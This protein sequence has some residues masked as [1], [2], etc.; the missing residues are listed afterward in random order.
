MKKV[1]SLGVLGILL[2]SGMAIAQSSPDGSGGAMQGARNAAAAAAKESS[3]LLGGQTPAAKVEDKAS[4][5]VVEPVKEA[6]PGESA[7]VVLSPGTVTAG[8][9]NSGIISEASKMGEEVLILQNRQKFFDQ[10]KQTV[11]MIGVENTLK[12]YPE[13]A[14]YLD[15]SPMALQSQLSRVQTLNQLREEVAKANGPTQYERDMIE[16]EAK[17]AAEVDADGN[18]MRMAINDGASVQAPE[19]AEPALTRD[20]VASLIE[21]ARARDEKDKEEKAKPDTPVYALTLSEVYG[22]NGQMVAVMTD[23]TSTYK[24]RTGDKVPNI[25]IVTRIERDAVTMRVN[26]EDQV[27]YFQ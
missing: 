3:R 2:S 19:P 16:A 13:Y 26:D 8:T 25:G 20:D 17:T 5:A 6:V 14:A 18:L 24:L 12:M 22:A 1:F 7:P 27:I 10:I 15:T 11:D 23:G 21:E 4:P 9:L